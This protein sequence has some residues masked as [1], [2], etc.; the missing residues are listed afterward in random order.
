MALG[1]GWSVAVD[2]LLARLYCLL[3]TFPLLVLRQPGNHLISSSGRGHEMHIRLQA[4]G[5]PLDLS[6]CPGG[7]AL[8]QLCREWCPHGIR[9]TASQLANTSATPLPLIQFEPLSIPPWAV[10]LRLSGLKP[11]GCRHRSCSPCCLGNIKMD[12]QMSAGACRG[13]RLSGALQS[14]VLLLLA[15]RGAGAAGTGE[16]AGS[17]TKLSMFRSA[18]AAMPGAAVP[19]P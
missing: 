7:T 10:P 5:Q 18:R 4:P 6:P 8:C 1:T 2:R 17:L 12:G 14:L 13:H 3:F 11:S 15:S 19:P 9:R 16:P